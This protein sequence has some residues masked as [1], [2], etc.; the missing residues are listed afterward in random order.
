MNMLS[1]SLAVAVD[2]KFWS[3]NTL[4]KYYYLYVYV[5]FS[6]NLIPGDVIVS[7]TFALKDLENKTYFSSSCGAAAAGF[8]TPHNHLIKFALRNSEQNEN[9]FS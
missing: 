8:G 7:F 5:P 4:Q 3:I 9:S 6:V 1:Y 2:G